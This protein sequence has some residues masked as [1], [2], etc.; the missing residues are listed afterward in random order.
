MIIHVIF[1]SIITDKEHKQTPWRPQRLTENEL[2][3]LSDKEIEDRKKLQK[4][5][6]HKNVIV[7]SVSKVKSNK[8]ICKDCLKDVE[9]KWV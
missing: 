1:Q 4:D 8:G 2:R 7:F 5:C 6:N 9:Q 3:K